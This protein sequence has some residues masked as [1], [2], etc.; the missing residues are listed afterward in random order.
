MIKAFW[1][2]VFFVW[3]IINRIIFPTRIIYKDKNTK[4]IIKN[5]AILIA[6]HQSH[7]DGFVIPQ[8]LP[9]R[10]AYVLVTRKWYDKKKYNTMFR[11]LNYIPIDLNELDGSWM[12]EAEKLLGMGRSVL[13]FPEGKLERGERQPFRSGFLLPARHTGCPVIPMA[14]IG[15]YKLFKRQRLIIGTPLELDIQKKGRPSQI[16]K[17]ASDKCEQSVFALYDGESGK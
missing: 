1:H 9:G 5:G 6:N 13:I 14:L 4:K 12:T 10:T 3:G 7:K 17:D 15:E 8:I 11:H 2:F 16:L